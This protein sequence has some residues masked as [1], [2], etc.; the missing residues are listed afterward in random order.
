[1]P[2]A[3]QR[4]QRDDASGRQADDRL[5]VHLELALPQGST[6]GLLQCGLFGGLVEHERLEYL[7]AVLAGRLG[8]AHRDVG[9][10]EKVVGVG[11][12]GGHAD[13]GADDDGAALMMYGSAAR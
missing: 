5:V 13:A 12:A 10:A 9:V 11:L 3:G 6:E 1:M 8:R 7:D 4:L 2:P